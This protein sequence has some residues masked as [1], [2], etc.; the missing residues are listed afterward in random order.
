MLRFLFCLFILLP[1][2]GNAD[3]MDTYRQMILK[4]N[5]QMIDT[6]EAYRERMDARSGSAA[7]ATGQ[8]FDASPEV[9]AKAYRE[10]DF[11]TAKKHYE[12]LAAEG[13]AEASL[14]LGVMH[15]SGQGVEADDAAAY[16]WFGRAAEQGSSAATEIVRGMNDN[17]ELSEQ[18]YVRARETFQAINQDNETAGDEQSINDTFDRLSKETQI[19]TQRYQR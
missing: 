17:D 18:E 15:Q 2:S 5:P 14:I 3:D 1:L 9:A 12:A 16:A 7:R 13:D 19:D 6:L 10:K 8:N 11:E 4:N